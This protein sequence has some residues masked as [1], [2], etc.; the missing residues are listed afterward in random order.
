MAQLY[1]ILK[2]Y[3]W[4]FTDKIWKPVVYFCK[5]QC[6]TI[7]S[8]IVGSILLLAGFLFFEK[9][10]ILLFVFSTVGMVSGFCFLCIALIQSFKSP[11]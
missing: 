1:F 4:E 3:A 8:V 5:Q 2:Y 7:I 6:Y 9:E 10:S 11:F